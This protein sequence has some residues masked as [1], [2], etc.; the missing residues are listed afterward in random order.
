[1]ALAVA[2]AVSSG[3]TVDS[4]DLVQRNG[5][6]FKKFTD[7]PF[8]GTTTGKVQAMYRDGVKHGA[9][10]EYHENGRLWFKGAYKD[11]NKHGPWGEYYESGQL[12]HKT[13]YKE[14]REHGPWESYWRFD[15][16]PA[17]KGIY[18][19]G[20]KHGPWERFHEN[21]QLKEKGVYKDHKKHGP[22]EMYYENGQLAYKGAFRDDKE[23]GPV[24]TYYES[25]QRKQTATYKD[26]VLTDSIASQPA[27]PA[28]DTKWTYYKNGRFGFKVSYPTCM[29]KPGPE[30]EN[31]D[32]LVFTSEDGRA[33]FT[34]Y[35]SHNAL[36]FTPQTYSDWSKRDTD[37]VTYERVK[38][39]WIVLS[40]YRGDMVFYKKTIFSCGNQIMNT[41]YWVY[42]T[43]QKHLYDPIVGPMTKS[44]VPGAGWGT[45]DDCKGRGV[46]QD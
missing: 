25:G 28:P 30:P 38:Q 20:E 10:V 32:G 46:T 17:G 14:G 42:P 31:S 5:L 23:H 29:F 43:E 34:A 22:W 15:G 24:E 7:V 39:N 37:T 12:A 19:D 44:L 27:T 3:G 18:K 6:S 26:G 35:G 4:D 40:G 45:P 8:T 16:R 1:M 13:T 2:P 33:S 36:D 41:V 11:D 21:G 9:Y